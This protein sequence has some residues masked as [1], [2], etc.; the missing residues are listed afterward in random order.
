MACESLSTLE[1][2]KTAFLMRFEG[3][4]E[5]E[6]TNY[7]DLQSMGPTGRENTVG[8]WNTAHERGLPA[9]RGPC[10]PSQLLRHHRP[11]FCPCEVH[12]KAAEQALQYLQGSFE[13]GLTYSDPGPSRRNVLAGW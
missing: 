7:L 9:L 8:R 12:L 13:L 1:K 3:T 11:S 6:V 5:G 4:N 10:P 2:F